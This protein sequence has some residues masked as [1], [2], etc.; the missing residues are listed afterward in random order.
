MQLQRLAENYSIILF[1]A[2]YDAL[3]NHSRNPFIN[4]FGII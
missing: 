1:H 2:Y 4:A 3:Q